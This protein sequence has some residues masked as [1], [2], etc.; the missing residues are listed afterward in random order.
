MEQP[1]ELIQGGVLTLSKT[2]PAQTFRIRMPRWKQRAVGLAKHRIGLHNQIEIL[3]TDK[4]GN[5]YYPDTY[6]ISREQ[7]LNPEYE[8]QNING[9]ELILIPI[10]DLELLERE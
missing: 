9:L 2:T 4:E 6:Y 8:R 7:A 10:K 3:A 1:K 5:R